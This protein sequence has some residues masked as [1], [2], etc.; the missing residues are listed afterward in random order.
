MKAL[1]RYL[2][3]FLFLSALWESS[4]A[5]EPLVFRAGAATSNITPPLGVSIN[6]GMSDRRA[7]YIHDELHARCLVLDN[8]RSR[9]AIAICDSCMIPRW[10]FDEAKK[11]IQAETG[12]AANRVLMAATHTHSAPTSTGVFQSEPDDAYPKF[13]ARRI[14]D[15]IRRAIYNLAPAKIG[16]GAGLVRNHVFNRRWRMQ[17][18]HIPADPFGGTSDRVRMNPPR[19]DA[20]LIERCTITGLDT[21]VYASGS[22]PIVVRDSI[23]FDNGVDLW[24]APGTRVIV[25]R[26]DI[27]HPDHTGQNGNFALDPLFVD[28]ASEDYRLRW[29]SPC[30]DRL[31][32]SGA[33]DL[34]GRPRD[35]DGD[36]DTL[37]GA[38]VG[39]LELRTLDGPTTAALGAPIVLD[40]HGP[41]LQT[42][43]LQV[44]RE[45]PLPVPV[46]TPFGSSWLRPGTLLTVATVSTSGDLATPVPLSAPNHPDLAGLT[47][48]Y[49]ALVR[50]WDAPAGGAWSNALGL[51]LQ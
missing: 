14:A 47:I 24:A 7:V 36:L 43:W 13:L 42:A 9:L 33:F 31:P 19:G 27:D 2:L 11:M 10:V 22:A 18:G 29:G 1:C 12:L 20:S 39:A 37:P 30:I 15:G 44:S 41:P 49:Q 4:A 23:V 34:T 3:F 6:G 38:D 25:E 48:G 5:E 45:A 21:G 28:P 51:T 17:P 8:G 32:A 35:V 46:S 26:C 50:S 40:V 16:I